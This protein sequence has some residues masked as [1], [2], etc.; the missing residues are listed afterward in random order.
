MI[1]TQDPLPNY[2]KSTI[3]AKKKERSLVSSRGNQAAINSNHSKPFFGSEANKPARKSS[4]KT[5][6]L[7]KPSTKVCDLKLESPDNVLCS[8]L[9]AGTASCCSSTH[10]DSISFLDFL[11]SNPSLTGLGG[12]TSSSITDDDSG[13]KVHGSL[14]HELSFPGIS[15]E[16]D[17]IHQSR[18]PEEE[19]KTPRLDQSHL[20]IEEAGLKLCCIRKEME[21]EI[22]S[23]TKI[24]RKNTEEL[25]LDHAVREAVTKLAPATNMQKVA[26]LIKAFE[27]VLPKSKCETHLPNNSSSIRSPIQACN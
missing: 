18:N 25:K 20:S 12:I 16:E 8:S 7:M 19:M 13:G 9:N 22:T 17:C 4:P 15:F 21:G 6:S 23:N 1:K 2:M 24:D 10:K 11:M 5:S 26:M 27:T 3:S 14:P